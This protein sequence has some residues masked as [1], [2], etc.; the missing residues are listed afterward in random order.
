MGKI[1]RNLHCRPPIEFMRPC[2]RMVWLA[3]FQSPEQPPPGNKKVKIQ[4]QFACASMRRRRAWFETRDALHYVRP[5]FNEH[6]HLLS[7]SCQAAGAH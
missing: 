3:D 2:G 4:I 1:I 7:L 6:Q 5:L